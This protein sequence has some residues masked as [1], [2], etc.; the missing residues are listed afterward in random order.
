M[1][2]KKENWISSLLGYARGQKAKFLLSIV[3]SIIS[4][5]VGLVPYFCMYKIIEGFIEGTVTGNTILIWCVLALFSYLIK[6]LF[7]AM[8]TWLSHHVAYNILE[9]LRLRV[10]D[11][12]LHAPLGEVENYS[13][14]EIKNIIV[15]KIEEIEPPLAHMVPEGVGHIILPILSFIILFCI[16][17][18]IAVASLV[19][20]PAAIIC[21]MITFKISGENFEKYNESNSYMNSTIVEY[22]EGIEVIKA[23]G[24]AGVCYEK[25][26]RAITDYR[27]FV[28]KWMSSTWIT[29]KLAFA[30]FPSTLIGTLPVSLLLAS[31][32][33]ITVAQAALAVM[34]SI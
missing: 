15:D 8:S 33:T 20:F 19:T 3:I 29:V 5:A 11:R 2:D 4:I 16:N 6:I 24:R 23:F 17:W 7:F 32:G 1:N 31:Q 28:V 26:A 12:F 13:I 27:K 30:L 14:G 21:M 22:I 10:V 34:L 25:Y 18:R 9:G